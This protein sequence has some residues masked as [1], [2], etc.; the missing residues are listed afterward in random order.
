MQIDVHS[1]VM[2]RRVGGASA[3]AAILAAVSY[4]GF[5]SPWSLALCIAGLVI[6]TF[7]LTRGTPKSI[8]IDSANRLICIHYHKWSFKASKKADLTPFTCVRSFVR[9]QLPEVVFVEIATQEDI[10]RTLC[11]GTFTAWQTAKQN[12]N[13]TEAIEPEAASNLRQLASSTGALIDQGYLRDFTERRG[14]SIA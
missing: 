6:T 2:N 7:L 14:I 5:L 10:P 3:I 9:G 13:Y 11:I 4:F 8:A 1:S 12:A